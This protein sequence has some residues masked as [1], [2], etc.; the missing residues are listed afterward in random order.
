METTD[1]FLLQADHSSTIAAARDARRAAAELEVQPAAPSAPIGIR[2]PLAAAAA[3]SAVDGVAPGAREPPDRSASPLERRGSPGLAATLE[4]WGSPGLADSQTHSP[5]KRSAFVAAR[6]STLAAAA[7]EP[8]RPDRWA[9]GF[10]AEFRLSGA[11]VGSLC[12][13][14]LS[15]PVGAY[16]VA[17][18]ASSQAVCTNSSHRPACALTPLHKVATDAIRPCVTAGC[19]AMQLCSPP[20]LAA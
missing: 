10:S 18:G 19:C 20:S 15:C 17:A 1:C 9:S 5:G 2:G 14:S 12:R 6:H 7:M 16:G 4:R 8:Q 13:C 11:A 3:G